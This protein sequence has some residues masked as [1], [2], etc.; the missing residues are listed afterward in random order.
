[1]N[2]ENGKISSLKLKSSFCVARAD[3]GPAVNWEDL[4]DVR[5]YADLLKRCP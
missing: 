1:M 5:V 2:F 3:A 4:K